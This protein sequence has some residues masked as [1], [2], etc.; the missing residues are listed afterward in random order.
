MAIYNGQFNGSLQGIDFD[1]SGDLPGIPGPQ[2]PTGPAGK[3]G[4]DG[5]SPTISVSN[6]FGGHT[7]TITD[8]DGTHSFTVKDGQDGAI[9]PQGLKGDPG[10]PGEKGPQG[11]PGLTGPAGEKG[12]QGEQGLPGPEGPKG[13]DGEPGPRG[14]Q[15]IQGEIGPKGNDGFSP[16][17]HIEDIDNGHRVIITDVAGQKT[18]DV[19]NAENI[20]STKETRI[21]TW[22]DG[23][24]LYRKVV[25]TTSPTS[26]NSAADIV[27]IP[28]AFI[29][30]FYGYIIDG[31]G[32]LTP[33]NY[34]WG[35]NNAAT[36]VRPNHNT[37][38]MLVNI[39]GLIN[40]P[41]TIVVK[42]IK[43]ANPTAIDSQLNMAVSEI[44]YDQ[45]ATGSGLLENNI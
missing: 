7:V 35:T 43:S 16:T 21:G 20:Y 24:P 40:R 25:E 2:G 29:I 44:D 1:G 34:Y 8:V 6:I 27:T 22:I 18:F 39:P 3:D 32:Y 14:E 19:L 38:Q 37:L 17:I 31:S 12:P 28:E 41:V 9:G 13:A 45:C 33:I 10:A 42:Y 26:I 23:N 30:S 36:H 4:K 5:I 15:G 11:D